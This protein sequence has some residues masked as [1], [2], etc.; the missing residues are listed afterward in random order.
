MK[1][2]DPL[3]GRLP[4]PELIGPRL[5]DFDQLQQGWK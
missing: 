5:A 2:Q 1:T 4:E 3:V